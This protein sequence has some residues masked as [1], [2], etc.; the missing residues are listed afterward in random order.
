M[1][2]NKARNFSKIRYVWRLCRRCEAF[3]KG[4]GRVERRSGMCCSIAPDCLSFEHEKIL[5]SNRGRISIY[6]QPNMG[7]TCSV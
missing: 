4:C 3:T 6:E 7:M 5:H 2:S 1:S